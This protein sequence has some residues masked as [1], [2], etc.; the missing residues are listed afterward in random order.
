MEQFGGSVKNQ[1]EK[2]GLS[3]REVARKANVSASFLS[4]IENSKALPS[5][6]AAKKIADALNTTVGF[7]IGEEISVPNIPVIRKNERKSLVNFGYGLELQFLST[8][9]KHHKMEPTIQILQANAVS[10]KPPYQHEGDEFCY[11][12]EGSIKLVLDHREIDLD[13]G[14]SIYFNANNPHSIIN[15]TNSIAKALF[16]TSPSFF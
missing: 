7:L 2:L 8:I 13:E 6:S 1:R 16:V 12:L 10:G 9:D 11:V 15:D 4:Q 3:L 14:D 5:L